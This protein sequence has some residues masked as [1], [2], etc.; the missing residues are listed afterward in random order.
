MRFAMRLLIVMSLMLAA[1]GAA[2]A[3]GTARPARAG[4]ARAVLPWIQDD[5]PRAVALAK[6]RQLPIFV[7]AW[8]PW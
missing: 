6:A 4:A 8:A 1:A 5:Y 2:F 3:A 7:E